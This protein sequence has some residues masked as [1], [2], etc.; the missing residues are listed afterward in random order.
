[1]IDATLYVSRA[2]L[3]IGA[4][5]TVLDEILSAARARNRTLDVTGALIFTQNHFAQL[6]EGPAAA[7]DQLM[8]SIERD[9]RHRDVKI[10]RTERNTVRRFAGWHMAYDGSSVFVARHVRVLAASFSKPSE[11][12]VSRLVDLMVSLSQSQAR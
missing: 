3:E 6:L 9:P 1:M 12:H 7:I 8:S 4:G 2:T 11:A 10:V 5:D